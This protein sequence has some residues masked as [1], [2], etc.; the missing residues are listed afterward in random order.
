MRKVP[1]IVLIFPPFLC[2]NKEIIIPEDIPFY[3]ALDI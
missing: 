3:S 1:V 2:H